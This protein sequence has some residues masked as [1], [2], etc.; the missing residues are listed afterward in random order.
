MLF[1]TF[2]KNF[3]NLLETPCTHPSSPPL[4]SPLLPAPSTFPPTPYILLL[5]RSTLWSVWDPNNLA[6]THSSQPPN[7]HTP[8]PTTITDSPHLRGDDTQSSGGGA[9]RWSFTPLLASITRQIDT[10]PLPSPLSLYLSLSRL[11]A[12]SSPSPPPL[13]GHLQRISIRVI[14]PLPSDCGHCCTDDRFEGASCRRKLRLENFARKR[15]G[16][17]ER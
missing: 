3:S 7:Q 14:A 12:R 1:Y 6:P 9:R 15:H 5:A 8:L 11:L 17:G 10:R 4:A 16:L 2:S 13:S